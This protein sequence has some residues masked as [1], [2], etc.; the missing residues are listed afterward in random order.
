MSAPSETPPAPRSAWD[1]QRWEHTRLRRRML[2]GRWAEDLRARVR[3]ELGTERNEAIG[4]PDLSS[5]V[6]AH[7]CGSISVLYDV[8]YKVVHD[9]PAAAAAMTALLLRSGVFA[10]MQDVQRMTLG[11]REML[12][13]V[14]VIDPGEAAKAPLDRVVL[15]VRPVP[16]DMVEAR[17][18][19]TRVGEPSWIAEAVYR[20][21]G[22]EMVWTWEVADIKGTL[23]VLSADRSEDITAKVYSQAY[24]GDAYPW[25]DAAGKPV[26]PY[27]M[28]HAQVGAQLWDPWAWAEIVEGTLSA[29]V[30]WTHF[31][32][33][34]R[35]ASWPQRWAVGVRLG[36]DTS[37]EGRKYVVA[38]PTTC[39]MF[40]QKE[41]AAAVQ[42][43]QW[44]PGASP[45]EMLDAVEAYEHRQALH[46]V[47]ATDIL[48]A[49]GDPRSGYA[50]ALSR[51]GRREAA[52]R[53]EPPFRHADQRLLE[54]VAAAVNGA[55]GEDVLPYDGWGVEYQALPPTMEEQKA[56]EDRRAALQKRL[57]D[58]VAAQLITIDQARAEYAAGVASMGAGNG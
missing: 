51:E 31:G 49:S 40:E 56:D 43:G 12:L 53:Y 4:K 8:P 48:R 7:V 58:A 25:H 32:H 6:F 54:T 50:L 10:Q 29:G 37:T 33:G 47:P 36:T 23:R 28:Y 46:V 27:V 13:R 24:E 18:H 16:P 19:P 26:L 9:D 45:R 5:N 57:V 17:P 3:E 38:D 11:L 52:R 14:D 15:I 21:I 41:D 20:D 55:V 1:V 35:N 22:G 44:L 42:I 30:N 34:L 2:T 39:V